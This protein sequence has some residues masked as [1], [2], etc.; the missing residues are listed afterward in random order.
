MPRKKANSEE[1]VD[2]QWMNK[3]AVETALT[4]DEAMD[5]GFFGYKYDPR[6]NEDY[7]LAGSIARKDELFEEAPEPKD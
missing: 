1:E 4:F 6:P 3:V 7:T 2:N 5:K